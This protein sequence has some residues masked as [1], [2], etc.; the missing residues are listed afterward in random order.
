MIDLLT[1]FVRSS[2]YSTAITAAQKAIPDL[3]ADQIEAQNYGQ[4]ILLSIS[5]NKSL[6]NHPELGIAI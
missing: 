6:V 4:G 5:F 3:M 2:C 1:L